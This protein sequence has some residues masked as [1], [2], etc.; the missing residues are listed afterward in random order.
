MRR[1]RIGAFERWGY[2]LEQ[3]TLQQRLVTA[4]ILIL[5]IPSV[6][7]SLYIF[8]GLTGNTI[9]ELKKNSLNSL[10]IEQIHIKNNMETMK[11]AAQLATIQEIKDYLSQPDEPTVPELIDIDT[12][13]MQDILRLQYNNPSLELIRLYMS[14]PNTY[15][16][17]PVFLYERRIR[18]D[19][20][21]GP[22]ME[23]AGMDVWAFS[24]EKRD[25]MQNRLSVEEDRR[26][27]ISLYREVQNPQSTHVGVLEVDMLL[28]QFFPNTFNPLEEEQAQMVVLDR[29]GNLFRH[30]GSGFLD[31]AGL[32]DEVLQQQ[33]T[34]I[35]ASAE[36]T[37]SFDFRLGGSQFLA[38]YESIDPLQ[39]YMVKVVSLDHVYS[40]INRTRNRILLA[41][42]ILLAILTLATY[43][44]NAIILKKLHAL[45]D[46]VKKVRQGDFDIDLD[47]RGGGE[48]GE[49]AHHF[50]KMLRKMNELIAEA[51]GKQAAAKETELAA[52]KNQIDSH[53]LYNTLEN[54]KMMAEVHDHRDISDALT[55]LG[56][57]LRYNMRWNGD[58][59]RLCDE[60]SHIANYVNIAN[61]RFDRQV[62]LVTEIPEALM[63]QELL[64][65]SLQPIVENSVKHGMGN[66]DL[67]IEIRAEVSGSELV[68]S[69]TDDGVGMA[70]GQTEAL[71]RRFQPDGRPEAGESATP[72]GSGIGLANV[73]HRVR[74][75]YGKE[76]GL[77]VSSEEG[78]FTRV[79]LRLPYLTME[80]RA[81]AHANA[82]RRG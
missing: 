63:E 2:R 45:T 22:V 64:K 37:G 21:Y 34:A 1:F 9:E 43:F 51:V 23:A 16:I 71:N 47:I 10:E 20:W 28:D 12:I 4:Y 79:T 67:T 42:V 53:F 76:Y 19:P 82:A 68:L 11:R 33:F 55:S 60:L 46:S 72:K 30:P 29:E 80:G 26:P 13:R 8:R 75:H 7:I 58:Y 44:I 77:S 57:M 50:R 65:M 81:I 25:V 36:G 3:L 62:T 5:L 14:N 32:T 49:L 66:R 78:L 54:I 35:S 41:F 59:V 61:I 24:R 38:V 56:G 74:M 27:R 6:L 31:R 15:E 70:D 39:A 48:V 52:L 17:W 69:I 73:Q 40:D 18:Q